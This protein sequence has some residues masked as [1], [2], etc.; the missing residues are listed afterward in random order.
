MEL[1][2]TKLAILGGPP[3]RETYLSYGR[4]YI[5][6]SDIEAVASVLTSDFLTCGPK[7]PEL[8]SAL[9]RI[10]GSNY[11]VAVSNGTAALHCACLAAGIGPGDEVI[12]TPITFAAS[13]NCVLY[14]GGTPVFADIDPETWEISPPDIEKK[15][16]PKTKAV[17]AV[18]YTGQSC[19]YTAIKQICEKHHL[20][21]IEDAA[22][23]IGTKYNGVPVGSIADMTTF[24]FHPVKTVTAGE[25]GAI[26]TNS[27]ELRSKLELAAKHGITHDKNLLA[28]NP[29]CKWYYEEIALGYNYRITDIQ[30]AL[31]ISQ[32]QKLDCFAARRREITETYNRAFSSLPEI[33]LQKETPLSDTVRHIYVIRLDTAR[34]KAGRKEIFDAL[35]AENIGV[36]VHYIPVYTFPYFKKLG[37]TEGLCPH[38]EALYGQIVTLPLFYAM[39]D[40]D[41]QDVIGA[42]KKVIDYYRLG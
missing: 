34:L 21:L 3:V 41:V 32:L 6:E 10:G 39:T 14:C 2:M 20:L 7:I 17:I 18:D 9:C 5:D 33:I 23:A 22:H 40:R 24:S 36:N 13:A 26:L 30:S 19:D 35:Q 16:T 12:V 42:V 4:Q 25:G 11:A 28:K 1:S 27:S 29:D 8:E 15:I 37:Y 31:L 38:A